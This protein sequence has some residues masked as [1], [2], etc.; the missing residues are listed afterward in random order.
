MPMLDH[1]HI[2]SCRRHG[3]TIEGFHSPGAQKHYPPEL[4]LEPIHLDIDLALDLD[5]RRCEGA[6]TTTVLARRDGVD[7][8]T[9]DAVDFE[10]QGVVDPSGEAVSWRY[11]GEKLSI[12][13]S[14]ALERGEERAV[15]VRYVVEEPAAGLYFSSPD[16]AYPDR[17]RYAATDHETERA[18]HWLPCVDLPNVRT[19]LDFHLRAAQDL[20][21]L[22]NGV[23]VGQEAHEDG[24]R[25][26]H[27]R[28]AQPCPSYLVCFAIGD[29]VRFDD[30]EFEGIPVAAFASKAHTVEDLARSFGRTRDML[31]WMTDRLGVAF[32]YPKYF[33]FALPGYGGAMENISLVSWDDSF[34][35]DESLASEWGW[36]VDQI[37]VHEMAHSYFGDLVVCRDFAH[38]W[39]KESWATYIE[40]CW[41][42]HR[43]ESEDEHR[44]DLFANARAY[45]QEADGSY[46][47][48]IVTRTF[49]HSWDMY[50]RHLYP[51]G[52]CRLHTLRH[53]L[54]DEVFWAAVS[55]YLQTYAYKVVETD[56]FR[57][58]MEAHSGRSLVRFFEQWFYTAGYPAL[59]VSFSYD[60]KAK[61]GTFE[62]E[63][64]QVDDKAGVPAFE[65]NIE[66]G[67]VLE[68]QL[69]RQS[70][71]LTRAHHT[72]II[73]MASDPTMVRLDPDG[74]VLHKLSFNP[75]DGKLRAQLTDAADVPGRIL[76]S[77][78]LAETGRG[79]NLRAI[80]DAYLKEPFWGVRVSMAQHLAGA[81]SAVA[82]EILAELVA[83]EEDPMVLA[84][85][86]R[87]AG[88]LRD[89]KLRDALRQR[90]EG[91]L[92]HRAAQAA[93]HM[94]GGQPDAPL[95]P[96]E[97]AAHQVGF[98]GVVQSGALHGLARTRREE[99]LAPLSALVSYGATDERARPAAAAALG[100]LGAHLDKPSRARVVEQLVDLL[101]DP[102]D[103]VRWS[104]ARGLRTLRATEALGALE[105]LRRR[106]P[107]QEA[108]D[109]DR[110]M[111]TIRK[112]EA[113]KVGALEKQLE[114]TRDLV[115]KL[116]RRLDKLEASAEPASD[117]DT[118]A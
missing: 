50:D 33:Q 16:E 53:E 107:A 109:L 118:P 92:P 15:V 42:E 43:H 78:A 40:S 46:K 2:C 17:A 24:T 37:N 49:N 54:G 69:R 39:L 94:L 100:A 35:L 110:L 65:L 18:R 31:A 22:A 74:K 106:L 77:E 86:I 3:A 12:R 60:D 117:H 28:L 116:Q 10:I 114:E 90:L 76:A 66:L 4:G 45:F 64:T 58:I 80:R 13:W 63:Q 102:V 105:A 23:R 87:V 38:A 36:L 84:P 82:V 81:G 96:L 8:L 61:E 11:D 104:A 26:V 21:I 68:G 51:G 97:A 85:L 112:G 62:V 108:I 71:H 47:R 44:Y 75:G 56:D 101:R 99:A 95:E 20:T 83:H 32:P 113:P 88:G 34:V 115:R 55:D 89:V 91:G 48:P 9:L 19:R 73:P 59:K 6:V 111:A 93:W 25:T 57:R 52:A 98:N 1:R 70:V 5:A 72:F 41:L 79:R 14:S 30:D 67:W 7:S 29:L 27:W 103:R